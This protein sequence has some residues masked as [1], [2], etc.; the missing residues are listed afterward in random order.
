MAD[1]IELLKEIK[2]INLDITRTVYSPMIDDTSKKDNEKDIKEIIEKI[3]NLL[4]KIDPIID[5]MD[6]IY[7]KKKSKYNR[8]IKLWLDTITTAFDDLCDQFNHSSL[9]ADVIKNH[10]IFTSKYY[11]V[12]NKIDQNNELYKIDDED[13][14]NPIAPQ[15]LG[16]FYAFHLS[17]IKY[18]FEKKRTFLKKKIN[19]FYKIPDDINLLPEISLIGINNFVTHLQSINNLS[20][21]N[22]FEYLDPS[23]IED[24]LKFHLDF[25][26]RNGGD[27]V[28]WVVH[29]KALILNIL[30]PEQKEIFFTWISNN[31][32]RIDNQIYV[33]NENVDSLKKQDI[34]T[35]NT[36][37]NFK[38][39]VK[40]FTTDCYNTLLNNYFINTTTGKRDFERIFKG[41][42]R[43]KKIDWIGTLPELSRFVF[44]LHNNHIED[45]NIAV[46]EKNK[47][48]Y[49]IAS[50]C[51]SHN[52]KEI[53]PKQLANNNRKLDSNTRTKYLIN[54]VK[55]LKK[56][57]PGTSKE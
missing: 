36:V 42:T 27:K 35:K 16:L 38:L 24:H 17:F 9:S 32:V 2:E 57:S 34:T 3:G 45:G 25:Y 13:I 40:V 44:F 14:S 18:K 48:T 54:A 52:G 30:T 28:D 21:Q 5:E 11:R 7:A 39:L 26:E 6:L 53:N 51:F 46:C 56:P 50:I 12:V 15:D 22:T 37:D 4:I 20:F 33:D 43:I 19:Y 55:H 1:S 31:E 41:G 49:L 23:K 8:N 29:T 10:Q 47:N